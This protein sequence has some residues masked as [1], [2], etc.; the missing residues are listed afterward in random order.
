LPKL[1]DELYNDAQI[2]PGI[3]FDKLNELLMREYKESIASCPKDM[4]F[5][6]Y[7]DQELYADIVIYRKVLL[8]IHKCFSDD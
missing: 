6:Q 8:A 1:L 4:T 2:L 7:L 3:T 5:E